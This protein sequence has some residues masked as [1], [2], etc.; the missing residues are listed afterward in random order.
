MQ[1]R[2]EDPDEG[3]RVLRGRIRVAFRVEG[4][5]RGRSGSDTRWGLQ[6][7]NQW[8]GEWEEIYINRPME[9]RRTGD[10]ARGGPGR[11]D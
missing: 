6:S 8:G 1:S 5:I 7:T 9:P 2:G 3:K 4:P 11:G 10:S